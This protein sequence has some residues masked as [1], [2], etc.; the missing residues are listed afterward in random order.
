[1]LLYRIGPEGF[2]AATGDDDRLRVLHSDPFTVD[3]SAWELGRVYESGPLG[4]MAPVLPG[5]I[6]GVGRNY[7]EHARELGNEVPD[8][9]LLF[10]KSPSSIVGPT[11]SIVLPPESDR[12]EFEGEVALVLRRELRRA[13][14]AEA[15]RALLGVTCAC[16]V[17]ARDLQ[18]KDATFARSKSFDTF[19]PIGPAIRV[20]PDLEQL[21]LVTRV[22]GEERQR[23][24]AAQMIWG[25]VEL[26]VYISTMMTL[27]PGDV[28][29]TGTPSGVG[30]LG[31]GDRLEVE[32]ADVG[33]LENPVEGWRQ[34]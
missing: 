32:I 11:A 10:L 26:L 9:P 8:E 29:L 5:K 17:T 12:V 24:S 15:E 18:K 22:N 21:D 20:D 19:C 25:P 2:Y 4:A 31:D 13:S 3:P 34:A 27:D 14:E 30:P 23:G 33:V 6:V 16:D 28:V 7:V 1:M